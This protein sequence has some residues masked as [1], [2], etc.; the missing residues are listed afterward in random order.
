[1]NKAVTAFALISLL[2]AMALVFPFAKEESVTGS[3][4]GGQLLR[5]VPYQPLYKE[6]VQQKHDLIRTHNPCKAV[7]C[8]R[9]IADAHPVIG[10]DGNVLT[11]EYGNVWCKCD[12]LAELY[13]R[14]SPERKY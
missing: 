2:G 3:L 9:P 10:D 13:Y 7:Q 6:Q 12:G 14:V 11:D 5:S 8:S 4:G 1:M